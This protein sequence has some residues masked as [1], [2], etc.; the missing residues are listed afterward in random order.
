MDNVFLYNHAKRVS[1]FHSRIFSCHQGSHYQ[2]TF[3]VVIGDFFLLLSPAAI[4]PLSLGT[5]YL[6]F[7]RL[8]SQCCLLRNH[9]SR[10]LRAPCHLIQLLV[11]PHAASADLPAVHLVYIDLAIV[12]TDATV[13]ISCYGT[14]VTHVLLPSQQVLR[15]SCK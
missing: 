9:S 10:S 4:S 2:E 7:L 11:L 5:S 15:Q 12:R 1:I 13:I 14:H 8:S 6:A 3:G